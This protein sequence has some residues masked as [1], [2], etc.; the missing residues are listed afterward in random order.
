MT[1]AELAD[2]SGVPARTLRF[3]IARGLLAGPA[4]VG[5]GATYTGDH[6]QRVEQIKK[7]QA[8]GRML[9]EIGREL[10]GPP[11]AVEPVPWLHYPIAED[12][13]VHVRAGGTPWRTKQIRDAL[14][15]LARRLAQE[16]N[17]D[18]E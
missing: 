5:R 1:L 7:W 2:A 12:L 15:D 10:A 9:S 13:V 11:D 6:L 16:G 14:Q 18:H 17:Q 3:Y 8:E 4:K